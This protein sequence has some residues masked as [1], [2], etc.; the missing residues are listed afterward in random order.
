MSVSLPVHVL[1][2]ISSTVVHLYLGCQSMREDT[3]VQRSSM[4]I[5]ATLVEITRSIFT[6]SCS[7]AFPPTLQHHGDFHTSDCTLALLFAAAK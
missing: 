2:Y 7:V 5:L 6:H 1:F 3:S 4:E